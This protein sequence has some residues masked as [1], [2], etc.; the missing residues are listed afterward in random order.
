MVT[1]QDK[2]IQCDGCQNW[3]HAA[4]GGVDDETYVRF[5]GSNC[6]WIC[7]ICEVMNISDTLLNSSLESST[8]N[9]FSV[10]KDDDEGDTLTRHTCAIPSKPQRKR[11]TRNKPAIAKHDGRKSLKVMVINFQS[12]R[13]KT[14]E[15]K[16]LIDQH[17]PDIIQGTETWLS[18]EINSSEIFPD[19]YDVYR[20]DRREGIHGGI[21][22]ACKKDLIMIR[23]EEFET[24]TEI[25]W[26]QIELKG[27]RSLLIGTAYKPRH[28]DKQFVYELENSFEKICNKGKGYNIVLSGDFNQ[29]NISWGDSK[30][31]QDHSASKETA[32]L[33][34]GTVMGFGLNQHVKEPTRRGNILDLVF[35]NNTSLVQGITVEPGVSDHDIVITNLDLSAKWKRQPRRKYFVRH[36]AE[37]DQIENELEKLKD[38]FS[39]M[40]KASIQEKWDLFESKIKHIMD[41]HIPKKTA[42]KPGSLPWFTRHH[43]RLRRRKQRAYNRARKTQDKGDWEAFV[44]CQKNLRKELNEAEQDFISNNLITTMKEN[45]K[46]FWSYMKRLGNGEKGVAD[47]FVNNTIISDSQGK[48]EAL[49]HQFASVFTKESKERVPSMGP[50]T[51][52]DIPKLII[53]EAGVLKQ[54]KNLMPNKAP[55]PDQLPPW[56]LKMFAIKLAPILTDIFQSSI[57]QESLPRQWKEANI[58]AILKKGSKE[59]PDSYRPVSLTSATCK[60][61]EHII[62]SHIMGHFEVNEVLVDSQHGFRAKRSTETQLIVTID[63]I[64]RALDKGESIHMA[65]L[66]FSKAF[67]KVPHERLLGKLEHYGIRN[68]LQGWI[69]DFLTNRIQRVVC[70]GSISSEERVLSGVPQGTV[71]GP[72]L[73]LSYINDLPEHI[74]STTRLFADDCLI[75][76]SVTEEKDMDILQEDLKAL[77]TWQ[78]TWKMSFN[79]SKC[80][81]MVIS[82]KKKPPTRDYAFCGQTL[83]HLSSQPYLGVQLD[84]KLSWVEHVG[85]TV[86]KANRTLGFLRR[87]LWFCPKEVKATA[88]VTLVRPILEYASCAWDP[89]KIG[90]VEKLERIQ[91]KAARFCLGNFSKSSSVTQMLADLKWET[92]GARRERNRLAMLYKIQRGM[93]GISA[94]KYITYLPERK[95]RKKND[96]QI[97]IPFA[98]TD[99]YK[100]SFF[101]RTS[102]EWNKLDNDIVKLSSLESFK[103]ALTT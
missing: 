28:D 4:C 66:D 101:V 77:E 96:M 5:Q 60:I 10:L 17:N 58:C 62:H 89:H 30:I 47:L 94:E 59:A 81:I 6:V 87:N 34:L 35:S 16:V 92:L 103:G 65:I 46:Q 50:S 95:T 64:A 53:S 55:G 25:M 51:I 11:I 98:R 90:Q 13:N 85:N 42:A 86:A 72:L 44:M 88:Y 63:D 31:V 74:K 100:N 79:S 37:E 57:D 33:L 68:N 23:K 36:K 29:P 83:R 70:E 49:N 41:K 102:M 9:A 76:T 71:L 75:Y 39:S 14:S 21:L 38:Q 8:S 97:H 19:T 93:V 2:G 22:T 80:S 61:L 18:Q 82:N 84:S 3:I 7:P 32:E 1:N 78:D 15:L 73:F 48:A 20:R 12:I 24:D 45:T 26:N 27:R 43:H 99:T 69:R 54:L 52:G 56:F 40:G 67:D 91:R